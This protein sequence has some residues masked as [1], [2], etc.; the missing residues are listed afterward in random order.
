MITNTKSKDRLVH[1]NRKY[2][3]FIRGGVSVERKIASRVND[4]IWQNSVSG[5]LLA[6]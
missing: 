1:H 3:G 5:E 2:H 4:Y 6:A